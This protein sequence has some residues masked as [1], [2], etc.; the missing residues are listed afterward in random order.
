MNLKPLL[1]LAMTFSLTLAGCMVGPDYQKPAMPLPM[2]FKEGTQWQRAV[3][4][5]QGALNSQW[6]LAYNDPVLTQLIQ[7]SATANQSIVAAE[8]AYRGA[9]A[10][11]SSSRAGLWPTLGAGLSGSRG[12]GGSGSSSGASSAGG[13]ENSVSATL[14]ASWEPDLWGQV[15]RGIESSSASAQASD[16]LLASNP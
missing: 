3:A 14:T 5:P 7:R 13:V 8:A 2:G 10:Q 12:V 6:W 16:A 11:V 9:Q 4:N 15:R 1:L